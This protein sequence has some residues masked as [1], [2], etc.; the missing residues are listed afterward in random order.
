MSTPLGTTTVTPVTTRF[1]TRAA[2]ITGDH[3]LTVDVTVRP[4]DARAECRGCETTSAATQDYQAR[5]WAQ[6][7]AEKC[8]AFPGP[9]RP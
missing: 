3:E 8:R 5:D 1:L 2:E 7:H 9:A 6:S 4:G